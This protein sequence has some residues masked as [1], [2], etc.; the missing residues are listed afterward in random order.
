MQEKDI[1]IV[2]VMVF[3]LATVAWIFY[4]ISE[5]SK[6]KRRTAAQSELHGRLLDKFG[7]AQDL[8][9]FLQTPAGAQFVEGISSDR[10]EPS[11]AI[12]RA[13]HRGIILVIVAAGCLGLT[14]VYGW[15]DNPLL[16]IG[17][18][19]LCLGIGFLIS[20]VVSHKLSKSL[21][22]MPRPGTTRQ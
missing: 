20:A 10:E 3:S 8:V 17:V 19:L 1:A 9:A 4:L 6:R 22:L 16:V 21:G 14:R 2:L 15:Q 13:T 5:D 18:V 11:S 12:L 7:S